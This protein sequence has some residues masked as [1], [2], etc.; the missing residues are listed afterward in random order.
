MNAAER[1]QEILRILGEQGSVQVEELTKTFGVSKVTIRNDLDDLD[2]KGLLVRTHGGAMP[3]ERKEFVRLIS[4]TLY[5][6]TS[7]K[8]RIAMAAAKLLVS[9]Q[10]IIIDNG[11]TTVHMAKYLAHK[12]LTVATGS[13]L[14][15]DQLTNDESIDLIIIGGT[16]RRYSLG[17]IG[18]IARSCLQ[19]FHADWLFM[20]AAAFSLDKGISCTNLVEAETKQAMIQSAS[21]V[22]LLVD[23]SKFGKISFANIC[24]WDSIDVLVTDAIDEGSRKILEGKGVEV[25]VA[26]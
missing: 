5:E 11:S 3:A 22:C 13:I 2:Q 20:G 19:Q 12:N 1:K 7:E 10:S 4:N 14:A 24:S 9:G 18:S 15:I 25:I 21:K 26:V 8:E 17:A 16:L 23:S 6:A